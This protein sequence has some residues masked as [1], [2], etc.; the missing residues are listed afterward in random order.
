MTIISLEKKQAALPRAFTYCPQ[1][2]G[3]EALCCEALDLGQLAAKFGTPLYVYSSAV[4]RSRFEVFDQSFARLPHTTCYAVK[5][6]SNLAILKLLANLGAGFDIV[7]GGELARVLKANRRAVSRVVFSGVGKSVPEID[8]AL[9]NGILLF[10]LESESEMHCVAARAATLGKRARVAF[11]V[12]PDVSAGAHPYIS[13]GLKEHKFGVSLQSAVELYRAA[14][15]HPSLEVAGVSAHVGS[16]I[17]DMKP[18]AA[19]VERLAVLVRQLRSLKM[20]I[21]YLDAG[22]GLGIHY[23]HPTEGRHVNFADRARAYAQAVTRPLAGMK[24]HLLL[25]PGRAIVAPAGALLTRVVYRKQNE[26]KQFLVVDAAMNDLIRPSLYGAHHEIVPV[27]RPRRGARLATYDVVGPVCESTDFLARGR[28]LPMVAEGD[29]LAV[30]DAGAY[31][32]VLSSN[33]NSRP[34]AAE[35]MAEGRRAR[36]IR[37]R[38]LTE[39]LWRNEV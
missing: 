6:N 32:M 12:N 8:A 23:E 27:I 24:L 15:A 37:R 19:S 4:L 38:E 35:V 31:G 9:G 28:K 2:G 39:D 10:N 30:M 33:Y 16:Q 18:F 29:L 21:R 26:R 36:L 1:K 11:R 25:E 34:R 13:T 5:A 17:L 20:D 7:S 22:G 3:G 14:A